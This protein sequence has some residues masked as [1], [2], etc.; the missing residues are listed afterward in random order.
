MLAYT[1]A[2][3]T[4][5]AASRSGLSL[6]S[7]TTYYVSVRAIDKVQ[8]VSTAVTSDGVMADSVAPSA[9]TVKDG[10]TVGSDITYQKSATSFSASWSGYAD[11]NGSGIERYEWAIGTTSGGTDAMAFTSVGTAT[12]AS[13]SALSLS[14]NVRYFVTVKAIDRAGN[15]TS[16]TSDGALVYNLPPVV[17]AANIRV[18]GGTAGGGWFKPLDTVTA[19]WNDTRAGDNNSHA[20]GS[21]TIDFS[22]FGGP[23]SVPATLKNGLWTASYRIATGFTGTNRNV[24]VTVVDLADNSTTTSG[25]DNAMI[26]IPGGKADFTDADGDRYRVQL[27]GPGL[28]AIDID[29]DGNGRGPIQRIQVAGTSAVR[30][31]LNVVPLSSPRTSDKRVSIGAIAGTGLASIS[32]ASSDVVGAGIELTGLLGSLVVRDVADGASIRAGGTAAQRTTIRARR[33][34]DGGEIRLGSTLSTLVAQEIGTARITAAAVGTLYVSGNGQPSSSQ[35]ALAGNFAADF[36]IKGNVD[37]VMVAGAVRSASSNIGGRLGMLIAAEVGAGR[38]AAGAIGSLAVVGDVRRGGT[39]AGLMA[40]NIG[41]GRITTAA[42]GSLFAM[43]NSPTGAGR[44]GVAGNFAADLTVQRNVDFVTVAG[45]MR[46]GNW[47]IGGDLRA[48]TVRGAIDGVTMTVGGTL[49]SA[50]LAT[51]N[52]SVFGVGRRVAAFNTSTFTSSHL[53]V[54]FTPVTMADPMAG[55]TSARFNR[56]LI[57]RIDSFSVTARTANAFAGSTIAARQIGAVALSRVATDGPSASGVLADDSIRS[58]VAG[59]PNVRVSN[60]TAPGDLGK[61]QF[62]V[63]VV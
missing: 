21:V 41:T 2:G 14:D 11:V 54:G 52:G 38:I 10:H 22:R 45:A 25:T 46:G 26:A 36:D 3:I 61:G 28:L 23:Q 17:M 47:S 5:T 12:D 32:A 30:S 50:V 9:G 44:P 20:L 15:A 35:S 7:G 37:Y 56:A 19:T 57:T 60:R 1:S 49:N 34:G 24:A 18:A 62:R 43:V 33:I 58:V 13:T 51:V 40:R 63:R 6:I 16:V 55:V 31:V 29:A 4:G 8:N 39:L 59:S 42:L 53:H 27:T 48:L